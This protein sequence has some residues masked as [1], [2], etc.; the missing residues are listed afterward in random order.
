MN[1]WRRGRDSSIPKDLFNKINNLKMRSA[2]P[3]YDFPYDLEINNVSVPR[4]ALVRS[5]SNDT[6]KKVS[7]GGYRLSRLAAHVGAPASYNRALFET[8]AT[9]AVLLAAPAR[10]KGQPAQTARGAPM[11]RVL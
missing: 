2:L 7:P 1:Y 10:L 8:R 3:P 11:R 9:L 6:R 4:L 5:K